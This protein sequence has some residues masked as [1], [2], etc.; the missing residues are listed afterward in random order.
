M[1]KVILLLLL[2]YSMQLIASEDVY[3]EIWTRELSINAEYTLRDATRDYNGDIYITGDVNQ[4]YIQNNTIFIE[5]YSSEGINVFKKED[6]Y[7]ISLNSYAIAIDEIGN[8]YTT[9]KIFLTKYSQD[10]SR[11]WMQKVST[12]GLSRKI[13]IDSNGNIYIAGYTGDGFLVKFDKDGKRL[14]IKQFGT[15]SIDSV[16]DM[17]IDKDDNMYLAGTTRGT[18]DPSNP[19][20]AS[21]NHFLAKFDSSGNKLWIKQN[22]GKN[23]ARARIVKVDNSGYV[24]VA[25]YVSGKIDDNSVHVGDRDSYIIKYTDSGKK[26]WTKQFGYVGDDIVS[27]MVLDTAGNIYISGSVNGDLGT[28]DNPKFSQN[29]FL[30]KFSSNG[31]NLWSK[32]LEGSSYAS[33]FSIDFDK[34]NNLDLIWSTGKYFVIDNSIKSKF[35]IT[36]FSNESTTTTS[37]NLNYVSSSWHLIAA[38]LC[39]KIPKSKLYVN[40]IF[41]YDSNIREYINVNSIQSTKG[42]WV[43]PYIAQ[44]L[45]F[46]SNLIITDKIQILLKMKNSLHLGEWNLLGTCQDITTNEIKNYLGVKTIWSYDSKNLSFVIPNTLKAGTG[47]WVK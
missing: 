24:Y 6:K 23:A 46:E 33:S 34:N 40:T 14:W 31:D 10:G 19:P 42:Y 45:N 8:I 3:K 5:K 25:G 30:K 29:I 15:S 16:I 12:G 20:Q 28:K 22:V 41:E 47:F 13:A 1:L 18:F 36:R 37:N 27:N 9:G 26:V 11:I 38:P 4:S 35:F 2:T 39:Q 32:Q 17:T 7:Q 21:T 43:T 44:K